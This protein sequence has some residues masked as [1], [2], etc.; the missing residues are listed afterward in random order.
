[1][2]VRFDAMVDPDLDEEDL[3]LRD[4]VRSFA[5]RE[6]RPLSVEFEARAEDPG[7]LY[8]TLGSL[9]L[10][11][12]PFAEAYGGGGRPY[13][14]YLLLIEELARAW[15]A[16]AVGLGVHTLVCDAVQRFG[17]EALRAELLPGMLAGER[18][19]AYALTESSSGSDAASLRTRAVPREGG[20]R[21]TGRKQF[22]TRGGEADHVLVMARTGGE[23]PRGISAF[24]VDRGSPGFRPSRTEAKM[25]W[26]SSPTWELVLDDCEVPEGRR[27]GA[28]GEG[29]RVAMAALD[30]GRL[31]IAAC[32]V[33]IA[34]AALDAAVRF[35]R[36]RD[37]FGQRIVDFQGVQFLLADMATGVEAGRALYRRAARLKDAGAPYS[38]E[39][40]MAKLFCSDMA[41]RVTTDAVQVHGG[42]GYVEEFPVERYMREAKALQIVE[43]TNQIQRV[44][45][46]RTLGGGMGRGMGG[47]AGA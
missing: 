44:L 45:I 32:A 27:L 40:S 36:E 2:T 17:D 19:G 37:Q 24:V 31:G 35:A 23:G 14:T 20:Y 38:T 43:G 7:E 5:E 25:G 11:G 12:I 9:G 16:L 47:G 6:A 1:M 13:R 26:R 8:R 42:Y 41:M 34:Q 28:E 18:F 29:F 33:G 39:A 46:G 10:T 21:L 15:A 30:A 22:C 4:L 3:A